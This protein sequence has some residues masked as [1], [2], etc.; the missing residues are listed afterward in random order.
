[1]QGPPAERVVPCGLFFTMVALVAIGF[2]PTHDE[3]PARAEL[4]RRLLVDVL[5]LPE[6]LIEPGGTRDLLRHKLA[7]EPQIHGG[8]QSRVVF[9]A[10]VDKDDAV[11]VGERNE[12]RSDR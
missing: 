10:T 7:H 4:D 3:D 11:V 8:K 5:N 6:T 1:M 9:Y 12:K 2:Y